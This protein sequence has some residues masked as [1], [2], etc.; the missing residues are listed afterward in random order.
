MYVLGF[1]MV[2]IKIRPKKLKMVELISPLCPEK[3]EGE[4]GKEERGEGMLRFITVKTDKWLSFPLL[5][6]R[7]GEKSMINLTCSCKRIDLSDRDNMGQHITQP[8]WVQKVEIFQCSI[9]VVQENTCEND[10]IKWHII[11]SDIFYICGWKQKMN[12]SLMSEPIW[13]PNS[14]LW[15]DTRKNEHSKLWWKEGIMSLWVQITK[16]VLH[17]YKENKDQT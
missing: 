2:Q 12:S 10:N 11:H 8:L 16:L 6:Y 4:T 17:F 1:M 5:N 15:T 14:I 3:E 13:H 9:I 7:K